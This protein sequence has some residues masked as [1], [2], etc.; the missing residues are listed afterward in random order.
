MIVLK[1]DSVRLSSGETGIVIEL[2]GR[3]RPFMTFK[4]DSDG[5]SIPLQASEVNEV[6]KR[7]R[8][9]KERSGSFWH[10]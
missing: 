2:W 6:L 8:A 10:G 7:N 4:R 3:A 5:A 1:D 9:S